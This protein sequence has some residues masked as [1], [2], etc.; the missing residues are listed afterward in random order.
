LNRRQSDA[1]LRFTERRR[2]EDEAPRL[3]TMFPRLETLRFEV[4][5]RRSG[6]PVAE[7]GYIRRI[8]VEHAPALFVLPCGDPSCRDGGHDITHGVLSALRSG[9]ARFEGEDACSGTTGSAQ[10]S[11]ELQYIAFATYTA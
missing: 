11:R 4:R 10:C 5:E 3:A 6:A 8:V 9:S 7:A 2:R 1:S